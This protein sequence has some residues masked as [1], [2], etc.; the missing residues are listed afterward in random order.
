MLIYPDNIWYGMV[1]EDSLE[2]ILDALEEGGTADE[3]LI[4]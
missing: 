1:T 3:Y 2:E 4:A